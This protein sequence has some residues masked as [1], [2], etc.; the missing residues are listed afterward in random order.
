MLKLYTLDWELMPL[1]SEPAIYHSMIDA[2]GKV[3]AGIVTLVVLPDAATSS[4][5]ASP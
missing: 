5:S 1:L 4:Y 3:L 2:T